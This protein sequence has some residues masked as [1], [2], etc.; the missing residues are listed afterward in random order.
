[1]EGL[2]IPGTPEADDLVGTPDDDTLTGAAGD[3]TLTGAAGNDILDGGAGFD[4]AVFDGAVSGYTVAQNE[5]GQSTI[6]HTSSGDTDTLINVQRL[7]FDNVSTDVLLNPDGTS[8]ALIRG[9][10]GDFGFGEDFLPRNDDGSTAQIDLSPVFENGLN[11]FGTVYEGLWINNNGSVTFAS[12]R[13]TF[14]PDVITGVSNNPEITPFFAD[15]DTRGGEVAPTPGGNSQGSNLVHWDFN[16]LSDQVIVTWDDVGYFSS[17]TDLL[18]SFQLILSDRGNGDF[19]MQ[20][21]YEDVNWTTGNASGGTDGLGGTV[22]RAGFTAGTGEEGEFFEL[23]QSGIQDEMLSLDAIAGNTGLVGIWNF[24]VRNGGV[25]ESIVPLLPTTGNGAWVSGD[26]HL[27]TLDGVGYDFQAAGEFVLLQGTDNN[28]QLQARMVPVADN[29]SVNAAVATNLGGTAVMI[30][31]TDATPLHIGGVATELEDFGSITVGNDQVFREGDTYTIVYAG[32]DDVVGNGDSQVRVIVRDERVDIDV[33]LNDELLGRLEGL[34]GDGDGNPDNDVARADGSVLARPFAFGDL[35]GQ[36]REDWR[37]SSDADSLFTYDTGESL[38]GFYLPD[39]PGEIV[40][41]DTLDPAVRDAAITAALNAGL[42][43]GTPNFENAVLDFALTD[44]GSFLA[45]AAEVPASVTETVATD[46][47]V[48]LLLNGTPGDDVLLGAVLND[49]LNGEAGND[50]LEGRAGDDILNG[51]D[52]SD[53]L[54]GGVGDDTLDGGAGDDNLAASD[55]NDVVNG[56]DGK[57]LIGGGVGDDILNGE[58]GN[59]FMGGG[60]DNDLMDGGLGNDVVNGGAGDDTISGGAGNDTMGASLGTDVVNGGEGNDDLGGGAGQDTID[61]GAG[62]DSV[63]V[64]VVIDG[65]AGNDTMGASLGADVVNGGEG[66][67]DLGGGAGQDT[68]DAGAGDDSVGGGEGND[69]IL[70]GDGNDFLAGGGRNDVIDGG[71]GDDTINGGD[72]DDV[73]TGGEGADVFVFNFFKDGDEDVIADYEDGVDSFLIRLVNLD[74]GEANI[75]NGGNGL[76]GFVDALNI[77]DTAAGAQMDIGGHLV[78]VEGM[79]AADLTLDDF[80][81]I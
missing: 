69:S 30:D 8:P 58:D 53:A 38:R 41:L 14:T 34:L 25:V 20:F 57:D 40:T 60:Q 6:T 24:A 13:G 15:V 73:M 77:T 18:N 62:D 26:P 78:T 75:D 4:T 45:S 76:Q 56:G 47:P 74:T 9:L 27:A 65:G 22:A 33:R 35:Y 52:G 3:D 50:R 49:T 54:L 46:D 21:R 71:L 42:V 63:G 23:P 81:F 1:M 67:D 28:F 72:G 61:A 37:V 11:Y 39:F 80:A 36:F 5:S 32:A 51:G 12:P 31:A 29:V 7:Q 70:G 48:A 17:R 64:R 44:D 55:G 19:D 66:N 10:G 68:I 79:A 16:Q 2:N 43:E 59:D